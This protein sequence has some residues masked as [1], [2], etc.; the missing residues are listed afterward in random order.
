MRLYAQLRDDLREKQLG[1]PIEGNRFIFDGSLRRARWSKIGN[2][3]QLWYNGDWQNAESI[4]FNHI[5]K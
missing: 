1:A 4:D 2:K 3:F 5:T